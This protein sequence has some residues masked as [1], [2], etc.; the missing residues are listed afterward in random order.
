MRYSS[1]VDQPWDRATEAQPYQTSGP[2]PARNGNAHDELNVLYE[3]GTAS[4]TAARILSAAIVMSHPRDHPGCPPCH[5]GSR[6]PRFA[7][8]DTGPPVQAHPK[9]P[10]SVFVR[11]KV[12]AVSSPSN[13]A[14]LGQAEL[15]FAAG[16]TDVV[17]LL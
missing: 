5:R 12:T 15:G 3:P 16:P 14:V 4:G 7:M 13:S 9:P 2:W 17:T 1:V 11:S 10:A 6:S 8:T